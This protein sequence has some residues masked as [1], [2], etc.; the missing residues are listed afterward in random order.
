MYALLNVWENMEVH[1]TIS[2]SDLSF[3]T[4]SSTPGFAIAM[5]GASLFQ[6]IFNKFLIIACVLTLHSKCQY[7]TFT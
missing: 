7:C 5:N 6:S 2:S 3:T 4:Y 1:L